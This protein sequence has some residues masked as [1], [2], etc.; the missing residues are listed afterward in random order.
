MVCSGA[1]I[2]QLVAIIARIVVAGFGG[3][4]RGR[5]FGA[6]YHKSAA[7]A[8]SDGIEPFCIERLTY[9]DRRFTTGSNAQTFCLKESA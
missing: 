7:G 4:R 2:R 8:I 6:H 9:E 1:D 5:F 3:Y